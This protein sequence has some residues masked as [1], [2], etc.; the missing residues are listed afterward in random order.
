MNGESTL[1]WGGV[2]NIYAGIRLLG[3]QLL[4]V[5]IVVQVVHTSGNGC[6]GDNNNFQY[7]LEHTGLELD[8]PATTNAITY[9][10]QQ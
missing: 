2:T 6:G 4:L 3:G 10:L 1:N 9:K 5:I 8:L 7:K